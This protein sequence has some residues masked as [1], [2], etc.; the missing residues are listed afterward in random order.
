MNTRI[1]APL[2]FTGVPMHC[3]DCRRQ[4]VAFHPDGTFE[5]AGKAGIS[6]RGEGRVVD[7]EWEEVP[8]ILIYEAYCY[9]RPCRLKR[10]VREHHPRRK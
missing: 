8:E 10:W 9:R 6:G 7:G 1:G 5:L 4:L 3:P 2:P